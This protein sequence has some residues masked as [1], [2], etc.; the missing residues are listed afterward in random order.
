MDSR[1]LPVAEAWFSTHRLDDGITLITE[2]HV[3]PFIRANIYHV[4]GRNAD[5]VIDTGIGIASLD[6]VLNG[7]TDHS[8]PVIAVATHAHYDHIG[9]M[10]EFS[11]RLI[12]PNESALLAG[13][14]QFAGLFARDL[15]KEW[16]AQTEA[17]HHTLPDLFI[18]ALPWPNYDPKT[19]L[20]TPSQ[21]TRLVVEGDIISLGDRDFRVLHT[22]GHSAG[23][24]C[25]HD[26]EAQILFSGDTIY[27]SSL[28]DA[29]PGADVGEYRESVRRLR[30]LSNVRI[31]YPGHD[32][33]FDGKRLVELCDGYLRLRR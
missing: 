5:L 10:H 4:R 12:H 1:P 22:P 25:L 16:R 19:Y 2:P 9:G 23:G 26:L 11:E 27:D 24:I 14:S 32:P 29:L 28:L 31:V 33:Y 20:L 3:D 17:V 15:P 18:D 8:K 30:S 21:A 13:A 7:L 6:A